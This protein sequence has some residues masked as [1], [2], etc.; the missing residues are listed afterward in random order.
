MDARKAADSYL[1]YGEAERH[2]TPTTQAKNR[3]CLN[4][5]I[6]PV[7]GGGEVE[8]IDRMAVLRLRQ[9]MV[10]R[11]LS[12]A[13]QYSVLFV[14]RSFLNF[15]R[16]VLKLQTINPVEISL[17][18][19]KLPRPEALT[20]DEVNRLVQAPNVRTMTGLR[21]RA[22]IELLLATGLRLSEALSL[23]RRPIEQGVTEL[24]IRGKG[25]KVRTVF[26]SPRCLFWIRQYL[27]RRADDHA[28]LFVTTGS[29]PRRWAA[30][31]VSP[32]FIA[33]RSG[34]GITKRLTPH[35]LRHTFCTNLLN[36]GTDISFI[37]ELAGHEDI[38]TTARYY[39][40]IDK[41]AL[42]RVVSERLNYNAAGI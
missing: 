1:I 28:A 32:Y 17:P 13:R 33:L 38:D 36:N 34:V 24:D 22:F 35:L 20:N 11:A 12:I 26:F 41:P 5:W 2:Y 39:L 16:S 23:D 19:R 10:A 8:Q 4:S 6:L 21:L 30:V 18:H 15:G 7:L 40:G 31:D 37:K 42:R 9:L 27:S 25:G 29:P 3:D 14:L